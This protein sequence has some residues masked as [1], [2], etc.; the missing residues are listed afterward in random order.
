VKGAAIAGN[1][2]GYRYRQPGSEPLLQADAAGSQAVSRCYMLPCRHLP[3]KQT[4]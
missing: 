1:H 2:T 4:M 3:G